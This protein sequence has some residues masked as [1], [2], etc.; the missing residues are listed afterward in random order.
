MKAPSWGRF[1]G[2]TG[3]PHC[4]E[5]GLPC[6][7]RKGFSAPPEGSRGMC[8]GWLTLV[9]VP[10]FPRKTRNTWRWR[11]YEE[12]HFFRSAL[13]VVGERRERGNCSIYLQFP[14]MAVAPGTRPFGNANP[15]CHQQF[16]FPR[17]TRSQTGMQERERPGASCSHPHDRKA[18]ASRHLL[19]A[20]GIIACT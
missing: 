18:A 13:Y 4:H 6:L 3:H 1:K 16:P 9:A 11:A 5:S 7:P 8:S 2:P 19:P 14:E 10:G 15:L 17:P 20:I 12:M